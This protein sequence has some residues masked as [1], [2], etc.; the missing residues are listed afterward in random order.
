[1]IQW[2]ILG[3][4]NIAQRFMRSL[5][6]SENGQLYAAAS[7]TESKCE[8]FLKD[9]PNVLVYHDYEALLDDDNVDAVYLAM[10]HID[11][12]RWAKKALQHHKAVLCEKPATLYKWQMEDLKQEAL[13]NQT[14]FMEAMKTRFIP[15]I[16]DIKE[17]LENKEIGE[18][19]SVE[20]RFCYN[21]NYLEGHY[22]F[23]H[24]QGGILNDVGSYNV[25]S[26]LDYIH[27]A[28]ASID[29]QVQFRYGVDSHD[30]VT[31]TF[32]SGQKALMEMAFDEKKDPILEIIGT[33]GKILA[34]PFYRPTEATI[35][36]VEGNAHHIEKPYVND[37]FFGEIEEVHRCLK[38]GL[39]ESPRMSLQDSI[40]CIELIE[41]I[42]NSFSKE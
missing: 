30:Q 13:K 21:R 35:I 33:K 1:M 28:V 24:Q 15:L 27:S 8:R 4:G 38:E 42:R 19:L 32:E 31:I 17:C 2:G 26:T 29:S 23:D 12:Y 6:K 25:A 20:T 16:Q 18:L 3:I 22:L 9:H 11:H 5:E 34:Q 7:Y 14:F 36:D 37:D 39:V 10:R 40:D 41:K